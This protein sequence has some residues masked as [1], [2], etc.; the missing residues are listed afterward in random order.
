LPT[1]VLVTLITGAVTLIGTI[2][3]VVIVNSK[4]LYRMEIIEKN[5]QLLLTRY[6]NMIER[7]YILEK[8]SD[9]QAEQ[10]RV[11]NHRIEDLEDNKNK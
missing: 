8:K 9:V 2:I 6:D 3:S 4:N 10:I 5:L 7:I 11:A 1:E